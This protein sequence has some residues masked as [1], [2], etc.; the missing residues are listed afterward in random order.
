MQT[1]KEFLKVF[2]I[3]LIILIVSIISLVGEIKIFSSLKN[4]GQQLLSPAQKQF[5]SL[6]IGIGEKLSFFYLKKNLIEEN[7]KLQTKVNELIKENIE[8]KLREKEYEDLKTQLNF[9]EKKNYQYHL[10]RVIGRSLNPLNQIIILDKGAK[11]GLK[12]GLVGIIKE[13]FLIGKLIKIDQNTSQLL[14]ISDPQ[15]RIAAS[16]QGE[17]EAS[18]VVKGKHG[19]SL[20]MDL[21]P[22]DKKI[23]PGDLVVTAG[24]EIDIPVGLIIGEVE[25]IKVNPGDFFQRAIIKPLVSFENLRIVT[26]I[27]SFEF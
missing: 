10:T 3:F 1:K 18:G 15:S 23:N 20:E 2:F 7:K 16:I 14:L 21:I 19:F 9:L 24:L 12:P 13:G 4:L 5:Y 22:L 26:V 17:N 27:S 8:L 25:E 11:D 6:G